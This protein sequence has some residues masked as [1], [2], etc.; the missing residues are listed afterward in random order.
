MHWCKAILVVFC[1]TYSKR[2]ICFFVEFAISPQVVS[3]MRSSFGK[4]IEARVLGFANCGYGT[5]S[6]YQLVGLS[7]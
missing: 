2:V 6:N 1:G 7:E 5:L 4:S 3:R